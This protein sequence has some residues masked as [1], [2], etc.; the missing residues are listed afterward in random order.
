MPLWNIRWPFLFHEVD[1]ARSFLGTEKRCERY[2]ALNR[3]I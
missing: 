1:L 2:R 3:E